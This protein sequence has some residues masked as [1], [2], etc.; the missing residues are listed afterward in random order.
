[1]VKS[2]ITLPTQADELTKILCGE[3]FKALGFT[4]VG[5]LNKILSPIVQKSI[6]R[7]S[8]LAAGFD[9]R[10]EKSGFQASSQW[11]IPHFIEGM[12]VFGESTIP[13][14]GPL[15]IASNHP[16]AYDALVIA[17]NIPRDDLKII[18]NIPLDFISNLPYTLP[19]F[20]YS[21]PDPFIRMNVVRSCLQH[22]KNGGALLIFASGGMD[23]DPTSMHGAKDELNNWSRSLE[24]F[25]RRIPDTQLVIT[26]VSGIL[27]PKYVS[28]FFMIFRKSRQDKQRVSE[29]FQ[30]MRQ[31][32]SPGILKQTPTV[33]YSEPLATE[34]L[35]GQDSLIPTIDRI[36][37]KAKLL[38]HKHLALTKKYS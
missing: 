37:S 35:I 9:Q 31:M 30:V 24:T 33:T 18:V 14:K 16:G 34:M 36:T 5:I 27:S 28:H 21:P 1:M 8:E 26:I 10:I 32:Q 11:M 2:G 20:L 3:F 22:L 13:R 6:H 29:F 4:R 25:I 23:P 38:L 17:A 15:L 12:N 7:F 19:H